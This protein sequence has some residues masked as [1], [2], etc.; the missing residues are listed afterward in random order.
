MVLLDTNALV[1][2]LTDH[3]RLGRRAGS[4]IDSSWPLNVSI[5]SASW[6]ELSLIHAT[7]QARLDESPAAMRLRL[8]GSG[9]IEFDVEGSIA[10]DAAYLDGISRDPID[11][12]IVA[13]ARKHNATLVTADQSMLDW[14]GELDRLDARK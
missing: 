3:K 5:S 10:L 8:V 13:T 1:W 11:R 2:W 12:L 7:G 14:H 9:L 4:R 6:Y